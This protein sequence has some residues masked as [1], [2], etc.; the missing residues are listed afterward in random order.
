MNLESGLYTA[1]STWLLWEFEEA[2][3]MT[4]I[5]VS[6]QNQASVFSWGAAG[7]GG[8]VEVGKGP[9]VPRAWS[10]ILLQALERPQGTRVSGSK[11]I[12]ESQGWFSA[13]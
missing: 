1:N 10:Q 6:G 7:D 8:K 3:G 5:K 2:S 9:W 12:F 13:A 11:S 4:E